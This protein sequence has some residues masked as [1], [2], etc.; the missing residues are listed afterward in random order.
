MWALFW[1]M[2]A[3]MLGRS[4]GD[5][6]TWDTTL[7]TVTLL[8]CFCFTLS[9][10]FLVFRIHTIE[11]RTPLITHDPTKTTITTSIIGK[12]QLRIIC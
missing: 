2:D 8:L 9:F 11:E 10:V 5:I 3:W 12:L 6:D 4:V 1:W 7:P